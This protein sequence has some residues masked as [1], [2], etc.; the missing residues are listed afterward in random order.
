MNTFQ[1]QAELFQKICISQMPSYKDSAA[2]AETEFGYTKRQ[3]H[4]GGFYLHSDAEPFDL[5]I[6]VA[7]E[8]HV[9]G[10]GA[11][12]K[13]ADASALLSSLRA[14]GIVFKNSLISPDDGTN[15]FKAFYVISSDTQDY[16][17][18]ITV[19]AGW[20]SSSISTLNR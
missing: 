14:Q 8:C 2:I 15:S 6:R 4:R 17:F 11:Q 16:T 5:F 19:K 10:R 13:M 9:D 3:S 12:F 1:R 7:G 18:R 20:K